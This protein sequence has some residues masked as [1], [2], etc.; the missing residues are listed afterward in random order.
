MHP[1]LSASERAAI[2]E[3]TLLKREG[4]FADIAATVLFLLL[5]A[6]YVTGQIVAVDGGRSINM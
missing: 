2:I 5:D 4:S 6:P 1:G 3:H